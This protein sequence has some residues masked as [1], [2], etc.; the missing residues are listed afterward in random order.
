MWAMW[1]PSGPML[2]GTT[3]IVRPRMAPLNKAFSPVWSISRISRGSIQLLVGPASSLWALQMKVRSSTRATSEASL[4]A[5]KLR[6][7]FTGSSF[8]RVPAAT[9]CSVRRWYSSALPSHQWTLSA[10]VSA[11]TCATHSTRRACLT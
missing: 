1:L 10:S 2:K 7:R 5:R 8:I 9:S 6:G 3:Y 11:A 4:R